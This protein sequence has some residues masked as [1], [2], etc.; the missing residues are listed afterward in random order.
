MLTRLPPLRPRQ[1]SQNP[2]AQYHRPTTVS[3]TDSSDGHALAQAQYQQLT[4]VPDRTSSTDTD[5]DADTL[6]YLLESER[7]KFSSVI[8]ELH[9]Q[10]EVLQSGGNSGSQTRT[11][12]RGPLSPHDPSV[13]KRSKYLLSKTSVII[14]NNCSLSTVI[15]ETPE[16]FLATLLGDYNGGTTKT[17]DLRQE[18]IKVKQPNQEVFSYWCFTFDHTKACELVVNLKLSQIQQEEGVIRIEVSSAG[19]DDIQS[20]LVPEPPAI[21][22]KV[23]RLML[24]RGEILLHPLPYGQTSFTFSS[25]VSLGELENPE[26]TPIKPTVSIIKAP[27]YV[28]NA[29][30]KNRPTIVKS[31]T[32]KLFRLRSSPKI[33]AGPGGNVKMLSFGESVKVDELF[34]RVGDLLYDRFEKEDVVDARAK[35]EFHQ[36]YLQCPKANRI[37]AR[38]DNVV[39]EAGRRGFYKGE[40]DRRDGQRIGR[41]IP[42]AF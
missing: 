29:A 15:H 10:V 40:K 35:E 16:E 19:V 8:S 6:R 38:S 11:T 3:K 32:S 13:M 4:I 28:L 22:S 17:Q 33:S 7:R 2:S 34:C 36:Q 25:E 5:A 27:S 9:Q 12:T 41:E 21:A 31:L 14:T 26:S 18:V 42:L 24:E 20:G 39:N 1:S 30:K 37:R 23:Y